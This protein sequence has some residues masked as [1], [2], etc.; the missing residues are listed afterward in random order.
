MNR[1]RT[2]RWTRAESHSRTTTTCP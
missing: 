1:R 2:N